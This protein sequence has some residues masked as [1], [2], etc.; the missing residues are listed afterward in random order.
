[1]KMGGAGMKGYYIQAGFMGF[2]PWLGR[3]IL[4]ATEEDY[5]DWLDGRMR[6]YKAF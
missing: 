2:V 3:Y 5:L 4:F 6:S 1:M